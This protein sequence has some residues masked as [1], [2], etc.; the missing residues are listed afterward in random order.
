M[1]TYICNATF[2]PK[3]DA[4]FIPALAIVTAP[5]LYDVKAFIISDDGKYKVYDGEVWD[6]QL[7]VYGPIMVQSGAATFEL[8]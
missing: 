7:N 1:P 6:Y 3:Q 5:G 8:E 2:R 4:A